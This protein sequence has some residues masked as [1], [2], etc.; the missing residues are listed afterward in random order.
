MCLPLDTLTH[1]ARFSAHNQFMSPHHG[2]H[3]ITHR[4]ATL[5]T[6]RTNARLLTRWFSATRVP[7]M[8]R[9]SH[10]LPERPALVP[11]TQVPAC[12][13]FRTCLYS[14]DTVKIQT[15]ANQRQNER[16]IIS[17]IQ[18]GL[19]RKNAKS[20]HARTKRRNDT[21]AAQRREDSKTWYSMWKIS[22][23]FFTSPLR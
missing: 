16:P 15:R 8:F 14:S 5:R 11:C 19:S 9:G 23:F 2:G 6:K 10:R 1:A 22:S 20:K 12:P 18:Q 4:R 21:N 13:T 3:S 17:S 7:A